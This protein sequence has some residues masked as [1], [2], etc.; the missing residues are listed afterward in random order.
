MFDK[1]A[2]KWCKTGELHI[3]VYIYMLGVCVGRCFEL[4]D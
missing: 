4:P 2:A 1:F 3:Y